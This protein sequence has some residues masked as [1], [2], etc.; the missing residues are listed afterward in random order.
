MS[1]KCRLFTVPR[2]QG[3]CLWHSTSSGPFHKRRRQWRKGRVQK[4][5]KNWLWTWEHG[6]RGGKKN[7]N[8]LL[9]PIF[10]SPVR[11]CFV[12]I[13]KI[14]QF[15]LTYFVYVDFLGQKLNNFCLLFFWLPFF[16]QN[17][18]TELTDAIIW[19]PHRF[20]KL[21]KNPGNPHM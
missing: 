16:C 7:I 10:V 11:Y 6:V 18:I 12:S 5:V 13:H 21:R 14:Q 9:C 17:F 4:I 3:K 1:K 19:M 8:F 20:Y 2:T 15:P